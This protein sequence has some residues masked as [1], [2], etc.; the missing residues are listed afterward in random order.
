MARELL[1]R[2]GGTASPLRTAHFFCVAGALQGLQRPCLN[3]ACRIIA[4]T[5]LGSMP[6]QAGRGNIVQA[7]YWCQ[8]RQQVACIATATPHRHVHALAHPTR[9]L[10]LLCV[11]SPVYMCMYALCSSAWS[12][13]QWLGFGCVAPLW[14]SCTHSIRIGALAH[15]TIGN[16]ASRATGCA[17]Q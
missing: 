4:A 10:A 17:Q 6:H 13:A 2:D 11:Q 15:T 14:C 12:T 7:L 16:R 1:A 8:V 9:Q 5:G 3:I